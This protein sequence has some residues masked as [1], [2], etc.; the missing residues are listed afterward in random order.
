M[1]WT[2]TG[3]PADSAKDAI[4]FLVGQTSTGDP[5]VV[6]DQEIN[7]AVTQSGNTYAAAIMVGEAMLQQF[8]G[9][10]IL[11]LRVGNLA[12][13]YGDRSERLQKTLQNLRRQ[14]AMRNVVPVAGGLTVADQRA[15]AADTTLEPYV[16]TI[17][18]ND[19]PPSSINNFSSLGQ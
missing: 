13:D 2:Y 3:N 5:V 10:D 14:V 4:R 6:S 9:K 19:N 7:W 18:M 17:G 8:S 11:S 1:S 15:R 16:F 12:E